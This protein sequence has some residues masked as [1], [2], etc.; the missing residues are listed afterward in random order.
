MNDQPGTTPEP[1]EQPESPQAQPQAH[2]RPR[3]R[4]GRYGI[5]AMAGA[6]I[7]GV[8]GLTYAAQAGN[9][10]TATA[11]KT[12]TGLPT[13]S[14]ADRNLSVLPLDRQAGSIDQAGTTDATAAQEAGLVYINTSVDY[15]A[16]Q[17][18]GTGMILTSDGEIL[19][20]HHVV[21]GATA[22]TVQ[23]VS[24]GKTY[25]AAVVGYDS[26]HDVAVLQLK[27]ASG[28][29]TIKPDTSSA[30]AVGDKVTGVGNA[31]GDGG[32]ASAAAG[33]V[34]AIDKAITVQSD[35]GSGPERL[36]GLIQ[37]SADIIAGDSGGALY[38]SDGEV[39]GMDTAASSGSADVT[40]YAIPI[41]QALTIAGQIESG[42]ESSTV[43]IGS[44]GF[45]GVQ[46]VP[47]AY[48]QGGG[49]V[50]AGTV[51]DSPARAAG[52]TQ[53]STITQFNGSSISSAADLSAAV[54]AVD[55]GKTATVSW[56][57]AA[58][59]SHTATVTLIAGPIG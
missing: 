18:A 32:A 48:Q 10:P 34:A 33:T 55:A 57:D 9:A 49:A 38:D 2:V 52:I 51:A 16:G 12:T 35:A 14:P 1:Q 4:P 23:V 58:G 29:T 15:G 41:G 11:S 26:T 59:T 5:A 50:V 27:D 19:T 37:V 53:G 40:G 56:T 22:I 36:S 46:L 43:H 25:Q 44:T 39:I 42:T 45:L 6:A 7:L 20:N 3:R 47:A 17:A 21:E 54:A 28:L 13:Q 31:N 30:V 8:S 24:T